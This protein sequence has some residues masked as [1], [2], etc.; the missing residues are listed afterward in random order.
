[1]TP[2]WEAELEELMKL[3]CDGNIGAEDMARLNAL[4]ADSREALEAY[5]QLMSIHAMLQWRAGLG[6]AAAKR[7]PPQASTRTVVLGFLG[8]I[9]QWGKNVPGMRMFCWMIAGFVGML[10]GL[11]TILAIMA[12]FGFY[13]RPV[14]QLAAAVDCQWTN[15]AAV[16][17]V[18]SELWPGQKIDLTAGEAQIVFARGAV[19]T[20]RGPGVL[21]VQSNNSARLLVGKLTARAE[22]KSSHGFA[23][24]TPAM[25]LTDQGTEFGVLV[26]RDGVE[27]VHV[28]RGQVQA[29]LAA[30]DWSAAGA[31][32]NARDH[33]PPGAQIPSPSVFLLSASQAIRVDVN[34]RTVA[35]QAASWDQFAPATFPR[36]LV[37]LKL[38]ES[39]TATTAADSS[40]NGNA[41][42]LVNFAMSPSPWTNGMIDGGLAF[43]GLNSYV[44]V[45][46]T[47]ALTYA[48]GG[49]TLATWIHLDAPIRKDG[50]TL[51]SLAFDGGGHFSYHMNLFPDNA[52][53]F[54]L[55]GI[56]SQGVFKDKCIITS[57]KLAPGWHHVAA[58]AD[59]SGAMIIYLD[60]SQATSGSYAGDLVKWRAPDALPLAVGT[61]YPYGQGWTGND[62]LTFHGIMDDVRVYNATLSASQIAALY[63]RQVTSSAAEQDNREAGQLK[64]VSPRAAKSATG[65]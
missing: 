35:Q 50:G 29:E 63:R 20:M 23:V 27:E 17:P 54:W 28:F 65:K 24:H 11:P 46:N 56:D 14:A 55:G 37:H 9:S 59:K 45:P 5:V 25:T 22:T 8:D 15:T 16:I 4:L 58:T 13:N 43:N 10:V 7:P 3:V 64:A 32:A 6:D 52:V 62:R 1:M 33:A 42:T 18:G 60:G 38:D 49:L 19:V 51:I 39:G 53:E 26:P 61:L 31:V 57:K 30:G 40:G 44:S 34:R 21:E 12:T 47:D 36:P 2:T 41:G 48:G